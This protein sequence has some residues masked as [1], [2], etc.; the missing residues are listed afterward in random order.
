MKKIKQL[1][2]ILLIWCV[3]FGLQPLSTCV[4]GSNA[5]TAY[6]VKDGNIYFDEVNN[7]FPL[8]GTGTITGC[9]DSV[10]IAEIPSAING[11]RV[12]FI[13]EYAFRG[14]SNLTKVTIPDSVT[15]I[16][17]SAFDGCNGLSSVAI[18][19]GVSSIMCYAFRD[20]SSL[21]NVTLPDSVVSIGMGAFR[22]CTSLTSVTIGECG[23][24]HSG[25]MPDDAEGIGVYAF[26]GCVNLTN[27]TLPDSV[28]RIG[29]AAFAYCSSLTNIKIPDS[30]TRIDRAAFMK[31]SSMTSI[32]IPNAV[33][34]IESETFSGCDGLTSVTISDCV[35]T[36]ADAAFLACNKLTDIYY[37]GS[38]ADWEKI[39]IGEYNES[40]TEAV[41]HYNSNG[42]GSNS[43][44]TIPIPAPSGF[45]DVQPTAYYCDSVK[46]AVAQGITS[47]TSATT[48]SP[49]QTCTRAQ[50][51]TFLWRAAGSPE[52]KGTAPFSDVGSNAYYAKAA[53]WAAE[54]GMVT[55][56]RFAAD[57]PCTRL[58]A[59]EY[60]WRYGGSLSSPDAGF[61]DVK[62]PAVDWA[63]N[64]GV[65]NGTGAITFSPEQTCTRAQ[66]VTFLYR[67]FA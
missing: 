2:S 46:W 16:M 14:C 67:A 12:V 4:S 52:P 63:V 15:T 33:T 28:N 24:S 27:I 29:M 34:S 39:D 35:T 30:V 61:D 31:C 58:E 1:L 37:S 62:S 64:K 43:N 41:I 40:L 6:A 21:T 9:D 57:T 44:T 48:F 59:V 54:H 45:S 22:D 25:A 49:E 5:D 20:C 11:K 38:Q 51:L 26:N 8:A 55:G 42:T 36:I 47:G 19:D 56:N 3:A 32:R 60:M 66:I 13:G 17:S 65:T 10:T 18:S 7:L 23:R 53:A 50:I